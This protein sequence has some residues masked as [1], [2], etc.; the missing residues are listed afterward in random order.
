MPDP[1]ADIWGGTAT[2]EPGDPLADIWGS[3]NTDPE[4]DYTT[5]KKRLSAE[6]Q[7]LV[8]SRTKLASIIP[9]NAGHKARLDKLIH[10][11]NMQIADKTEGRSKL[12]NF[13]RG[14][15]AGSLVGLQFPVELAGDVMHLLGNDNLQ[16]YIEENRAIIKEELD[17]EG[18]SGAAGE[19]FGGIVGSAASAGGL[20]EGV[21]KAAV[22]YLPSSRIAKA[23]AA[24]SEGTMGQRVASN[25]VTGLPIN[26]ITSAGAPDMEIPEGVTPEERERIASTN[27]AGKIKNLAIG[28]GADA[29]FGAIPHK[30]RAKVDNAPVESIPADIP[31]TPERQAQFDKVNAQNA[32]KNAIKRRARLDKD[33]ARSEWQILNPDMDWREVE[34]NAKRK[35]YDNYRERRRNSNP[36]TS[37]SGNPPD[38][39]QQLVSMEEQ[40]KNLRGERDDARRMA[41]TDSKLGIGND[42]ALKR[43]SDATDKSPDQV[44]L[45]TDVNGLKDINDAHGYEAG[46]KLLT[47]SRDALLG[48]MQSHGVQ[49]RLFRFGGDEIVAIVPREHAE[50]ILN[51][52]E[53]NSIRQYGDRTGSLSGTI[54]NTLDEA[55]SLEGKAALTARKLEA[56]AK[57]NIPGRTPEE[58]T[59]IDATR[60][61]INTEPTPQEKVADLPQP[62][63]PEIMQTIHDIHSA[64][65]LQTE[66]SMKALA[67]ELTKIY[68]VQMSPEERGS[69]LQGLIEDFTPFET[70]TPDVKVEA[71]RP[72]A[73]QE[74]RPLMAIKLKDG[75]VLTEPIDEGGHIGIILDNHLSGTDLEGSV[76]GYSVD[77]HFLTREEGKPLEQAY[78]ESLDQPQHVVSETPLAGT[79]GTEPPTHTPPAQQAPPAEKAT[80]LESV[81]HSK[82]LEQMSEKELSRVDDKLTDAIETV[83]QGTPEHTIIQKDFDA[84]R[85][86]YARRNND[87]PKAEQVADAPDYGGPEIVQGPAR[88]IEAPRVAADVLRLRKMALRKMSAAELDTYIADMESVRSN[89][90]QQE[91]VV[92]AQKLI[93]KAL[94]EKA[95]RAKTAN[96]GIPQVEKSAIQGSAG[97]IFGFAA[98]PDD[99]DH[100]DRTTNALMWAGIAAVG[101]LAVMRMHARAKIPDI[102][103]EASDHWPGSK[104][105]EE[106]IVHYSDIEKNPTSWRA[107]S[108][109]WYRGVVRR[110]F[111]MDQ[112]VN[113]LT[114]SNRGSAVLAAHRNPAKLAAMFGRWVSMS[115]GAI[116][117]KPSYIDYAGNLV[118]LPAMS[119]RDIVAIVGNDIKG[120]GKLMTARTSI[121]GQGLRSVPLDPV[122]ASLIFHNAPEKYHRAADA[123]RQFSLAMA[124]IMEKADMITPGSAERFASEEFYAAVKKV[125]DPDAGPS[126]IVRDPKTRK[127]VASPNPIKGRKHGTTSQ[128]YNPFE[129]MVSLI[130]QIYRSAELNTIKRRLEDL[131]IAGGQPDYILKRVDR[132]KQPLSADQQLRIDF[133]RQEVSGMTRADAEALVAAF[134][135]KSLDPRSNRM[136]LYNEGTLRTY[137]VDEDIAQ[138][139]A[140]LTPDELEGLWKVIGLPAKVAR[141]GVVLNPYFVA[142]Q[143]FIDGWQATLNSEYGF[144]PGIDQFLGWSKIIR[145]APEYREFIAGGGGNSTLQSHDYANV[146]TALGAVSRGAGGPLEIAVKQAREFKLIDA[147]RTLIIPFAEAARM[148]EYLRARD[149]GA[150]VLDAVYAAKHVTANF[151]QRGGFTA[152]R[153]L[154]RASMFLNPALQGLDQASFRAGINP[155]RVPAEGRKA[156]AAKYLSKAFVG[157]TL[158]SMYFW[159]MNKDDKEINDLRKTQSGA[160]YWFM[161]SPVNNPKLGLKSGDIVKIPK[162]IVDGQLFGTSM[163][164]Y[165]DKRYGDDPAQMAVAGGAMMKDISFNILPTAGV[166]YYGLQFNQ[167]LSFGSPLIPRGDEELSLEHMG[168][169]KASWISRTVSKKVAP[170]IG[171][172][173][174]DILQNSL[175]PAGLDYIV[176]T[177]GGML[178][179]DGLLA[180]SQAVDAESKGYVPAKEELPIISRIFAGYPSSN[181]MPLRRF[182]DRADKVQSVSATMRHLVREDP[183][184]LLPYMTS[185]Q[186]DYA[187]IG[188]VSKARQ[189]IANYRRAAQDIKDMPADAVSS[190]DRRTVLKRYQV[191]MI[192]TARQANT[193][194][195]DV[196][197]SFNKR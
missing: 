172:N 166:L 148:G 76:D 173:V 169:D 18:K 6:R 41:E 37:T 20:A 110:S 114:G 119:V 133:L 83:D 94:N 120:L 79:E 157:I 138:S 107:R 146:K 171:P 89:S 59:I 137:R 31:L 176:N 64:G 156:A 34:S 16:K 162:P 10:S 86:E 3:I 158:P 48:A 52:A 183:T 136:T 152:M 147:W 142:K 5:A 101:G 145:N 153:G 155:F 90:S 154:D 130:P 115:E 181:V 163:E 47:D 100:E 38:M 108:R 65:G 82:P 125:F 57:Q 188:V 129:T 187:L 105:A 179:R 164:A 74:K 180:I 66:E 186:A 98:D 99:P 29:L 81:E 160:K 96:P 49:P 118:P 63:P 42:L 178:G 140:S 21:G 28:I 197:K 193:F 1:L 56:K 35:I 167:N 116:M 144:R 139:M 71:N 92:V 67:E 4:P 132:V 43:A 61:R 78:L 143:S 26:A 185:N 69:A 141:Q 150:P 131:W 54:H 12:E 88:P 196:D 103:I 15:A 182:Y 122:T 58:Q 50:S 184:R 195:A 174:P 46:D 121:E 135:P 134:D 44:Y 30:G 194:A 22:R 9:A 55:L 95:F 77:N 170:L 159:F 104:T 128:I 23:I 68:D 109:N 189:D 14:S 45:F 25:V 62:L 124:T 85:D 168:E 70:E 73:T 123:A 51:M 40:L 102:K 149:H 13:V 191:L 75:R 60:E 106:K 80:M 19:I 151:S 175:T 190:E 113:V 84:V 17:P 192:E 27:V 72:E 111:A 127:L 11:I 39:N 97:F 33:L 165:L 2:A 126:K 177:V 117:D 8:D 87:K 24:A 53:K 7:Q 36:N 93:D 91:D 112:S 161:R 32:V